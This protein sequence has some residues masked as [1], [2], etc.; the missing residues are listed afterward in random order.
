MPS[1]QHS[2]RHGADRNKPI[3]DSIEFELRQHLNILA[4]DAWLLRQIG[5]EK[6]EELPRAAARVAA[7]QEKQIARMAALAG[8]PRARR[9]KAAAD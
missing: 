9:A 8:L 7:R 3:S 5:K 1:L 2:K 6:P 4:L